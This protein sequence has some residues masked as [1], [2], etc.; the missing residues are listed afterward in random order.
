MGTVADDHDGPFQPETELAN[1]RNNVRSQVSA[2]EGLRF[3]RGNRRRD[4]GRDVRQLGLLKQEALSEA[5]WWVALRMGINRRATPKSPRRPQEED[6]AAQA[7][8]TSRLTRSTCVPPR[9]QRPAVGSAGVRLKRRRP[10]RCGGG[11]G[12]RLGEEGEAGES[13]GGEGGDR[14]Q[15]RYCLAVGARRGGVAGGGARRHPAG[16]RSRRPGQGAGDRDRE[17]SSMTRAKKKAAKAKEALIGARPRRRRHTHASVV[18]HRRRG[19]GGTAVPQ[20][21][22]AR[23]FGGGGARATATAIAERKLSRDVALEAHPREGGGAVRGSL[24][25]RNTWH[26]AGAVDHMATTPRRRWSTCDTPQP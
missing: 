2:A 9:S 16:A 1:S 10:S 17:N 23:A 11:G 21:L 18:H 20:A 3:G 19:G 12:D 15:S 8:A 25:R 26:D 14:A 4:F 5:E 22:I 7:A 24:Q 13:G 6:L